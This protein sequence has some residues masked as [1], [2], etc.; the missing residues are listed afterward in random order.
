MRPREGGEGQT[1]L[2]IALETGHGAGVA[3][4]V[5]LTEGCRP[6][7]SV[8]T[9]VL[10][11]D[12]LARWFHPGTLRVRDGSQHR[13]QLV[14]DAALARR[15]GNL[16]RQRI[17]HR[18]VAIGDP[19]PDLAQAASLEVLEQLGLGRLVLAIAD[20]EAQ[21]VTLARDGHPYDG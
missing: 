18:L 16:G 19:Q 1:R 20:T 17:E 4:G 5:R 6:L 21:Y 8:L 15:R 14:R 3:L 11:D 9:V 13:I 10:I 12:R 7:L 2:Q